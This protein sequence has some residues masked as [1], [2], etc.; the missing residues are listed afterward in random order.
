MRSTVKSGAMKRARASASCGYCPCRGGTLVTRW[1]RASLTAASMNHPA[2]Q[3]TSRGRPALTGRRR[4]I[5]FSNDHHPTLE[6]A[7]DAGR[8]FPFDLRK[9]RIISMYERPAN[10]S[11]SMWRLIRVISS[12]DAQRYCHLRVIRERG[13]VVLLSQHRLSPLRL[14]RPSPRQQ[15]SQPRCGAPQLRIVSIRN[16]RAGMMRTGRTGTPGI[17]FA[18]RRSASHCH[19]EPA[20]ASFVIRRGLVDGRLTA[21][22]L[23]LAAGGLR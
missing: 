6:Y 16:E 4:S 9:R 7:T 12:V 11:G 8:T 2:C 13:K 3:V 15:N 10:Y 14:P 20:T 17:L 19:L 1:P 21:S 18:S 22:C 23:D 5:T